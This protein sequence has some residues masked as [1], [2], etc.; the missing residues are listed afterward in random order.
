MFKL[1]VKSSFL[2]RFKIRIR[3]LLIGVINL[4]GLIILI[5]VAI[6]A[7]HTQMIDG[8]VTMVHNLA[9][10]GRIVIERQ[11]ARYKRG[12]ISEAN[13]QQNAVEELRMMRYANGEYF[14]IDDYNGYSILL[15]IRPELEG[16]Y[17]LDLVDHKG[18]YYVQAQHDAALAGGGTV[19][20]QFTKPGT[21]KP[22]EKLAYVLPFEPWGWFIATG[23]YLDDVDREIG[24]VIWRAIGFL[25]VVALI[26]GILIRL[27]SRGVT[28]P[29]GQL[30]GAIKRL[31]ERDYH[32]P[33]VG[34]FRD[35]EVGDIARAIEVFKKTGRDF[36][37]L[38]NELREKEEQARVAREVALALERDS[39]VRLEQT[40]RLISMGEM[41]MSLAH[42]LNQPL[43]AVN[44]YCMGCVRRLEAGS[45]ETP[46]LLAAMKKA[47]EQARRASK[48]IAQLRKFLQRREPSLK[49]HS[50]RSLIEDTAAI[51]A[52]E[53]RRHAISIDI[54]LA[55]DLPLVLV[56]RVMIEQV[57]HNLLRNAIDAMHDMP[58][59]ERK[60]TVRT[61]IDDMGMM[62]KTSVIDYGH[63]VLEA[64]RNK[65]FEPFY[66]SKTE[67]MGVGLN[68][69]HSIL[70]FHGGRIWMIPNPLGGAI[71]EFTLPLAD[72]L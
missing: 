29:L 33:V 3:M 69:C 25:G 10:V 22:E 56:D 55:N 41:A 30:T 7:M 23:I 60:I 16:T 68:I 34:Q 53:A 8:R 35:D 27:L 17:V 71:F 51:V 54:Q 72:K 37:A 50:L 28:V 6:N 11:Y 19:R 15:P 20:Y 61:T 67:G 70:E 58:I 26:T 32:T 64:D 31:S 24:V 21:V 66:T 39:A 9:E 46:A 63:G 52:I 14:F 62:L 45:Q 2:P 48:I 59:K 5:V 36:E 49:P 43:A 57:V 40:A 18:R 4:A 1:S 38:Q 65:L 42:E 13:A 47:S 12:E 44:N